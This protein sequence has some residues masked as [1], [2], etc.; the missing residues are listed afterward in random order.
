MN[1]LIFFFPLVR[2][3]ACIDVGMVSKR[4]DDFLLGKQSGVDCSVCRLM[5]DAVM[6]GDLARVQWRGVTASPPR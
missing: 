6:F 2:K 5:S 3:V 4:T 1:A